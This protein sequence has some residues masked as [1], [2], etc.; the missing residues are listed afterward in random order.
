M[1]EAAE[2]LVIILSVAL[3]VFLV[4]G[5]IAMSIL[6]KVL[7]S[8]QRLSLKAE[9]VSDMIEDSVRSITGLKFVTSVLDLANKFLNKSRSSRYG[10]KY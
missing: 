4:L 3:A 6:I 7:K 5:I 10:K 8:L 1:N 9:E 2:I